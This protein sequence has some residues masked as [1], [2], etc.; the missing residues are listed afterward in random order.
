[1]TK[2]VGVP[3][4]L[5]HVYKAYNKP[6]K[7]AVR[8]HGRVK[9]CKILDTLDEAIQYALTFN[10]QVCVHKDNAMVDFMLDKDGKRIT[11]KNGKMIKLE[12]E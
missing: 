1:M 9:A 6:N 3:M 7:Y 12:E 4:E 2:L 11:Y 8:K 5:M 10:W